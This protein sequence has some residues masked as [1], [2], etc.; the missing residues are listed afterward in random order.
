M[1]QSSRGSSPNHVKVSAVNGPHDTSDPSSPTGVEEENEK[2]P[3]LKSVGKDPGLL[4]CRS[5]GEER[6]SSRRASSRS[7]AALNS[8]GK[9]SAAPE[10]VAGECGGASDEA[11][12]SGD[13]TT[14]NFSMRD[15]VYRGQYRPWFHSKFKKWISIPRN[16]S[17][18]DLL[19]ITG[20]SHRDSQICKGTGSSKPRVE[21]SRPKT[22]ARSV[23][24]NNR[25]ITPRPEDSPDDSDDDSD[26]EIFWVCCDHCEKW[27]KVPEEV[28]SKCSKK[29]FFCK[30][31]RGVTCSTPE[32]SWD[33][34]VSGPL[35]HT[36]SLLLPC[37]SIFTVEAHEKGQ[38]VLRNLVESFRAG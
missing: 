27:R 2:I 14:F 3:G 19:E 18:A 7:F 35:I 36:T 4:G 6:S 9:S 16:E 5:R 33:S 12:K 24:H 17:L 25:R 23:R 38:G 15:V 32:A 11:K 26:E 10:S 30:M 1:V 29:S 21:P 13:Q 20:G 22:E 37:T 31:I 8:Q 34:E 28:H